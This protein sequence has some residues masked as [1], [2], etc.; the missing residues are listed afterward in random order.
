MQNTDRHLFCGYPQTNQITTIPAGI[1]PKNLTQLSLLNNPITT[2]D[3]SAFDGSASTLDT[4]LLSGFRFTRI[5][6]AFLGLNSLR[7]LTIFD[8]TALDWNVDVMKHIGPRMETL[9]LQNVGLKGWPVWIQYFSN[10]TELSLEGEFISSIPDDA[11][12]ML[13][14]RLT[15]LS[16]SM[17]NLTSVPKTVS[18]LRALQSLQLYNNSITDITWLPRS[19]KLS[20]LALNFNSI[21][22]SSKL[23]NVLSAFADSLT[24]LTLNGNHLT[25]FP[26]LSFLTKVDGLDFTH[27]WISL[28]GPGSLPKTLNGLYLGFNALTRIP[29]VF[30]SLPYVTDVLMTRNAVT[31]IRD[32][33]FS[34]WIIDIDLSYNLV[35]EL[36][37][38]SFP[39][40][41]NITSLDLESN[42]LAV[43]SLH[44]FDNLP[45][46]LALNLDDTKLARLPLGLS[47]LVNVNFFSISNSYGLVCTCSEKS[48]TSWILSRSNEVDSAC[49]EMTIHDFFA[50][51]GQACP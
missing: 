7:Y 37:D 19:S 32:I 47:A 40:N 10:L 24:E 28:P 5:P 51:Y 11:L 21:A 48:L 50:N 1:L 33:D 12:D 25:E 39:K 43:I 6:D 29:E 23:S 30:K 13:A 16:L 44:V 17:N 36:T 9:F 34:P 2:I 27:N 41:S 26:D 14:S 4:L 46:L 45:K 35:K 42:P 31:E 15:G 20:L 3:D 22:D 8:S 38:N 49:G 18:S